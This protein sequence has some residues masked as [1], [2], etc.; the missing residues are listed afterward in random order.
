MKKILSIALVMLLLVVVMVGCSQAKDANVNAP[1]NSDTNKIEDTANKEVKVEELKE[2]NIEHAKGSIK[3]E[4]AAK[5]VVVFD[6][7][8]LDTIDALTQ[9]LELAVPT[10]NIPSSLSKYEGAVNA[11]TL[12]EPDMEAIFNFEP[13]LIIIGA[14]QANYYEEL[15]KIAPTIY[16]EINAATYMDD[17]KLS[18]LNIA[19]A[20]GKE[21]EAEKYLSEIDSEIEAIK[22]LAKLSEKKALVIMTNDGNLSAYGKGSRFGLIHDVLGVPTADDSIDVS[23]HGQEAS[24]EYIAQVN[25]EI[26]F[27]IDRT[28]VAGGSVTASNTLNNDLVKSITAFKND[29]VVYLNAE[30][31]YLANGGINMMNIMLSEVKAALN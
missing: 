23:T 16:V 12:F 8:S 13:E 29:K 10:S 17:F 26:L 1:Q 18:T 11:G 20:I 22:A 5:K 7:G 25:P 27:V 2:I 6:M 14:R 4:T 9:E 21:A 19:K 30:A 24:F 31:W 3:L 15:S 28:T